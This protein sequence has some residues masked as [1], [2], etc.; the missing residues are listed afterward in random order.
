MYQYNNIEDKGGVMKKLPVFLLSIGLL[1]LIVILSSFT[2]NKEKKGKNE[3]AVI[4]EFKFT[5][6][7]ADKYTVSVDS[8]ILAAYLIEYIE[9]R[10]KNADDEPLCR[11]WFRLKQYGK[12]VNQAYFDN[13]QPQGSCSGVYMPEI[14]PRKDYF[15]ASKFGDND[16]KLILIKKNGQIQQIKG[17]EFFLS[18]DKRY[19]ITN[20]NSNESGFTFFDLN[21]DKILFEGKVEKPLADWY[22]QDNRFYAT[23]SNDKVINNKLNLVFYDIVE[24]KPAVKPTISG[25]IR[26]DKK[27]AKYNDMSKIDKCKCNADVLK[28]S[29]SK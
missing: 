22:F 13:I 4:K 25:Y 20:H 27:L 23:V 26:M 17:G 2:N 29:L 1:G 15:I 28:V 10:N 3:E 6:Y 5:D 16:G 7:P 11:A 21:L 14:Q 8:H 12:V 19:I 18:I 9:V 24:N